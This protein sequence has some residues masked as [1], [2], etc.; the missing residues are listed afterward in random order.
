MNAPVVFHV[1]LLPH[2]HDRCGN[3]NFARRLKCNRCGTSTFSCVANLPQPYKRRE[4]GTD[5]YIRIHSYAHIHTHTF[6]RIHERTCR[7]TFVFVTSPLP[8]SCALVV[9]HSQTSPL[10]QPR[11][12]GKL[13]KTLPARPMACTARTTGNAPCTSCCTAA[14]SVFERA[15]VRCIALIALVCYQPL[16]KCAS[17]LLTFWCCCSPVVLTPFFVFFTWVR[18]CSRCANI[19]WSWRAEC[20]LCNAP[21]DK[22]VERREGSVRPSLKFQWTHLC[23]C[24]PIAIEAVHCT[25][26]IAGLYNTCRTLSHHVS[27]MSCEPSTGVAEALRKTTTSSTTGAHT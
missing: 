6:I 14:C 15:C 22:P 27:V 13:A 16:D 7:C 17:S 4:R 10:V 19:N 24:S 21:R 1:C 23:Y 25:C 11:Q 20:N 9:L 18:V 5:V 8:C 2:L 3:L 26:L 12:P